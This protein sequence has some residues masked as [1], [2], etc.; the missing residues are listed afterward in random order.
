MEYYING[1]QTNKKPQKNIMQVVRLLTARRS[2]VSFKK[3]FRF[4][5]QASRL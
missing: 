5:D 4:E 2:I 1:K 3:G